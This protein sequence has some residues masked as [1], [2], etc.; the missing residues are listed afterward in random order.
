MIINPD[1]RST[2][3]IFWKKVCKTHINPRDKSFLSE[4][5]NEVDEP[6]N[7]CTVLLEL[8]S[9]LFITAILETGFTP[10][11]CLL[12]FSFADGWASF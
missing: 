2:L 5:M 9:P 7:V 3:M 11:I 1:F 8:V 6:I 12:F 4:I 10:R